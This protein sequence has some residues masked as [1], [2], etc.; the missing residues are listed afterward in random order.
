MKGLIW[1]EF[2]VGKDSSLS[3]QARLTNYWFEGVVIFYS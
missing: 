3:A 1:L 2:E